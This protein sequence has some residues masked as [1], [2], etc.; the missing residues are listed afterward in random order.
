MTAAA[1]IEGWSWFSGVVK[2]DAAAVCDSGVEECL[3]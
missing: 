1:V 3:W 2:E